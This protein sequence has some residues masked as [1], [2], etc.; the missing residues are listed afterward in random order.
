MSNLDF[1]DSLRNARANLIESHVGASP[2]LKTSRLIHDGSSLRLQVPPSK[3]ALV[4]EVVQ[5]SLS[6]LRGTEGYLCGPPAMIDAAIR[7]LLEAGCRERHIFHERF[8]PS[9]GAP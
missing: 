5:R 7:T 1:S 3:S 8:V 4:T 2:I 9:G 6:D